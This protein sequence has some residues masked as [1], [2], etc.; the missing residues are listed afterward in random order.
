MNTHSVKT[1]IL[2]SA[3]AAA[4][5]PAMLSGCSNI[6]GIIADE[7]NSAIEDPDVS[8]VLDRF[9]SMTQIV[10]EPNG[11]TSIEASETGT[12]WALTRRDDAQKTAP[13]ACTIDGAQMD[14]PGEGL[15]IPEPGDLAAEGTPQTLFAFAETSI[16]EAGTYTVTC[17]LDAPALLFLFEPGN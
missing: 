11:D 14:E 7:V 13:D 16:T 4:S 12:L 8:D 2:V 10:G 17:D 5:L 3:L 6:E 9:G 15:N 1:S